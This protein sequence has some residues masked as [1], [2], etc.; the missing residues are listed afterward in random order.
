MAKYWHVMQHKYDLKTQVP[1]DAVRFNAT[2]WGLIGEIEAL[3]GGT[4]SMGTESYGQQLRISNAHNLRG[5]P[6]IY[7]PEGMWLV[8]R[9]GWHTYVSHETFTNWYSPV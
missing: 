2:D 4:A 3:T 6:T 7:I 5:A 1:Y 9:D 8:M